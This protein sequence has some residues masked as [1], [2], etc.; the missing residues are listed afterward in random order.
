VDAKD[1]DGGSYELVVIPH[2]AAAA[3]SPNGG[4]S[5]ES[6]DT[7]R[8]AGLSAVFVARNRFAVLDK[9]RQILIKNFA[10]EVTKKFAPPHASSD[11]LFFGGCAGRLLIRSEEGLVLLDQQSRRVLGELMLP[12]V[13]YVVWSH[14]GGHVALLSK[15]G[16][17]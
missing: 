5:A 11:M 3:A 14:D 16:A 10:N 13:K 4:G 8:G 1:A 15:Q 6:A 9:S 2:A 12:R 7:K 17:H